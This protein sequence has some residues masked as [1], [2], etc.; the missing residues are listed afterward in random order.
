MVATSTHLPKP[1]PISSGGAVQVGLH[2]GSDR[3]HLGA[4]ARRGAQPLEMAVESGD[5]PSRNERRHSGR[6]GPRNV[7]IVTSETQGTRRRECHYDIPQPACGSRLGHPM[8]NPTGGARRNAAAKVATISGPRRPRRC[9]LQGPRGS[10][11][12]RFLT[13]RPRT[14]R[15][16]RVARS[17]PRARRADHHG[18][19]GI[20]LGQRLDEGCAPGYGA[21]LGWPGALAIGIP[22][23][24]A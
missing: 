6:W 19:V 17:A 4:T 18:V 11:Q 23:G 20:P 22:G 10:H 15:A 5:A 14:T 1:A 2:R 9:P 3:P 8:G 13:I 7:P 24:I 21:G 16:P 12:R